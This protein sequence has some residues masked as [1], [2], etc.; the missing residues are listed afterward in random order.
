ME[1]LRTEIDFNTRAGFTELD[2]RL[3][4]FFYT[5][6]LPPSDEVFDVPEEEIKKVFNS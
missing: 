1:V 5:E 4:E 2:D 3:P 6:P